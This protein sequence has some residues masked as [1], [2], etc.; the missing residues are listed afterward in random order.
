MHKTIEYNKVSVLN[1]NV[2]EISVQ[3]EEGKLYYVL[4]YF[5]KLLIHLYN[6]YDG[7][8]F[9]LLKTIP[10]MKQLVYEIN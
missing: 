4:K 2:T 5:L 10:Q 6:E 3:K 7:Y 8:T 9:H 1:K